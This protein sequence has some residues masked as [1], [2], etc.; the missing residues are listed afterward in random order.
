MA[1]KQEEVVGDTDEKE[2]VG[3]AGVVDELHDDASREEIDGSSMEPPAASSE[4]GLPFA[5]DLK[6][7]TDDQAALPVYNDASPAEDR[8]VL[9]KFVGCNGY[10]DSTFKVYVNGQQALF[11]SGRWVATRMSFIRAA[12]LSGR[13]DFIP[14]RTEGAK[15]MRPAKNPPS[16]EIR[17]I[18]PVKYSKPTMILEYIGLVN[19][20]RAKT[21]QRAL[22]RAHQSL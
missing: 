2:I 1:K 21:G 19:Q 12:G 11:P 22:Q 20:Q 4:K 8:Y 14:D 16:F 6:D 17:K 13:L 10:P 15:N 18:E 7:D 3:D 9:A 5:L